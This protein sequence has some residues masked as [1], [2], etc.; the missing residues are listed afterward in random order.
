[1]AK[2]V[3][4]HSTDSFV[5]PLVG[6]ARLSAT[7]LRET[8][9]VVIALNGPRGGDA[10]GVALEIDR[11]RLLASWLLELADT[12]EG[13]QASD[14]RIPRPPLTGEPGRVVGQIRPVS[15]LAEE[16]TDR[17]ETARAR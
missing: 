4:L 2:I 16:P 12:A 1:M 10:G 15:P 11:A 14:R 3:R 17:P 6:G 7:A 13:G 9:R 5:L 8:P